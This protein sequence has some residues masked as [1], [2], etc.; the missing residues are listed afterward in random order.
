[1]GQGTAALS[2]FAV[3][4]TLDGTSRSTLMSAVIDQADAKKL[5]IAVGS[6]A[7][8]NSMIG[9]GVWDRPDAGCVACASEKNTNPG[10]TE[11]ESP[12]TFKQPNNGEPSLQ[13]GACEQ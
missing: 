5:C 1:M 2:S 10:P 4:G 12:T 7:G 11:N 9:N 6:D 8:V 3:V 13:S